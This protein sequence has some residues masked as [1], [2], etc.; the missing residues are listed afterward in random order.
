MFY[1]TP[2]YW[3]D[4][5]N[6]RILVVHWIIILFY[7]N[8]KRTPTSLSE[9]DLQGGQHSPA[10]CRHESRGKNPPRSD[11]DDD[12]ISPPQWTLWSI[13]RKLCPM[14]SNWN[15]LPLEWLD[16][17]WFNEKR[18]AGISRLNGS[19]YC[20]C[21]SEIVGFVIL[22]AL[23]EKGQKRNNSVQECDLYFIFRWKNIYFFHFFIICLILIKNCTCS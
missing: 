23:F 12:K 17:T 9:L 21:V 3:G 6:F 18:L 1:N 16:G 5:V 7:R 20:A 2:C 4:W 19:S 22:G 11:G 15:C 14:R 8:S 13:L 10:N